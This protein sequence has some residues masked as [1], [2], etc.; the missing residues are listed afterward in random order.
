MF[1]SPSQTLE[2]HCFSISWGSEATLITMTR[3]QFETIVANDKP[4]PNDCKA[5]A[6]KLRDFVVPEEFHEPRSSTN[7][8]RVLRIS[9]AFI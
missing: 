3:A 1:H 9:F 4:G 2:Q 6:E 7:D 5:K 8:D